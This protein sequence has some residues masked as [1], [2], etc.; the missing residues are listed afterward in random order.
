MRTSKLKKFYE[1]NKSDATTVE[2]PQF[3]IRVK[4]NLYPDTKE[5]W[6]LAMTETR[7]EFS[8]RAI[9]YKA[10]YNANI[11][12]AVIWLRTFQ[13]RINSGK[14]KSWYEALTEV[15]RRRKKLKAKVECQS[16]TLRH[17]YDVNKKTWDVSF[18]E[19]TERLKKYKYKSI[20]DALGAEN[21]GVEYEKKKHKEAVWIETS[22]M[23][24]KEEVVEPEKRVENWNR[25]L[26]LL[27]KQLKEINSDI[28][29]LEERR[30]EVIKEIVE[31]AK[32]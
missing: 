13:N 7:E 5:G 14:Y 31:E 6:L 22:S 26:D 8:A 15:K 10:F 16:K 23:N 17:F 20:K 24:I 18:E 25:V 9:P 29:R 32:R 3:Y 11:K 27:V 2:Y 19:F 28:S 4:K 30:D 1:R 21:I 12:D